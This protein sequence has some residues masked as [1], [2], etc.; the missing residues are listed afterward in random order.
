LHHLAKEA[1]SVSAVERKFRRNIDSLSQIF[2]FIEQFIVQ[3][4]A[5]DDAKHALD[6]AVDELFTNTV[7]YHPSNPNDVSIEL[8]TQDQAM[9][10]TLT[11]YDVDSF[12]PTKKEDPDLTGSLKDRTTGGL[13][14]F[15]TKKVMDDV[16][17]QYRNR[18]SIITLKRSYRRKNV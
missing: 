7:R 10:L 4:N 17:Y 2:E 1:H 3:Q 12:D 9:V 18:I 5:D 11:D 8:R 16:Q 15:L 13:G 14:I 6:L